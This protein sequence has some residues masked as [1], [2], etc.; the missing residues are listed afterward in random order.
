MNTIETALVSAIQGSAAVMA[1]ATA[2]CY[3]AGSIE[4]EYPFVV[5]FKQPRLDADHYSFS[6][7][8]HRLQRYVVKAVDYGPSKQRAQQIADNVDAVLTDSSLTLTGW[9]WRHCHRTGDVEYQETLP[10]GG[11]AWHVGGVYEITAGKA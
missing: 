2:I 6:A 5:F 11:V 10:D 7:R 9:H 1:Q 8:T 3:G 4:T